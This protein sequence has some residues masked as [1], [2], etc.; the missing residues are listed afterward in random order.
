MKKNQFKNII[1]HIIKESISSESLDDIQGNIQ[2]GDHLKI[3]YFNKAHKL[4]TLEGEV[5]RTYE[6]QYQDQNIYLHKVKFLNVSETT[7]PLVLLT[8][9]WD[10]PDF[11][12]N[13]YHIDPSQRFPNMKLAGPN[14][15]MEIYHN[16]NLFE[17]SIAEKQ[18]N[19]KADDAAITAIREKIKAAQAQLAQAQKNKAEKMREPITTESLQRGLN[20]LIK[21]VIKE[22]RLSSED[23]DYKITKDKITAVLKG[24]KASEITKFI[25]KIKEVDASA[26]DL[27]EQ[28]R[29]LNELLNVQKGKKEKLDDEI[30]EIILSLF[31]ATEQMGTLSI[32]VLGSALTL[33]KKTE[34]NEPHIDTI[35]SA[36]YKKAWD[37][38]YELIGNEQAGLKVKMDELIKECTVITSKESEGDKR[39]LTTKIKGENIIKEN[40]LTDKFKL[41][42]TKFSR[43]V[44]SFT[45]VKNRVDLFIAK[46]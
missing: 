10:D 17:I 31:D 20:K 35:I 25:K 2:N 37:M 41:F 32:D 28:K 29:L 8:V 22:D 7:S 12:A 46:I 6:D 9:T 24:H 39:K 15:V 5:E 21:Q 16:G 27:A 26:A 33:A 1:R 18:A 4:I 30:R 38:M 40:W 36:D 34:K 13:L 14:E 3:K 43:W 23:A 42:E 11:V 45:N 44:N 19:S